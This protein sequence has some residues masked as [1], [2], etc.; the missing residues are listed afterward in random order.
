MNEGAECKSW[1]LLAECYDDSFSRNASAFSLAGAILDEY[2]SDFRYVKL[3]VN[4]ENKGVYLLAEQSQINSNRVDIEE[5]G[6][7]TSN[8]A[9]GYLFEVNASDPYDSTKAFKIYHDGY[10]ILKLNGSKFTGAYG[11][12]GERAHFM[13]LKND[14]YSHDQL[15]FIKYYLRGVFEIMYQATYK[16]TA[17][18]FKYDIFGNQEEAAKFLAACSDGN[19]YMKGLIKSETK[20]PREAFEAV[21]D[22]DS[23]VKMYIFSE[24]IC[25]G[26]AVWK[27]YYLWTDLSAGGSGKLTFGCP[28]DHDGAIV[29]W[30][31]YD[32]RPTEGYFDAN[33]NVWH[34]IAMYNGWFRELVREE[35]K[36]VY[37]END[38]F[39]TTLDL[40]NS[41]S[42]TYENEF[43][44][45]KQLWNRQYAQSYQAGLTRDWL[46]KRIAWME[47]EFGQ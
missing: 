25:N 21:V 2:S 6:E 3:Y 14:G 43:I 11:V 12:G 45:E 46:T 22:V 7:D 32:Y 31:T 34:M 20:T 36:R 28:W 16:N 13:T 40:I 10:D 44:K 1:V 47:K 4:G 30:N 18:E 17:Y 5:A 26:D 38:G 41:V 33:G 23:L 15:M 27:S 8:L 19:D 9:S 39:K 24:I 42:T 37:E 29:S 35:W